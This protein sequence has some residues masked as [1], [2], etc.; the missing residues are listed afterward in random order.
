VAKDYETSLV[1]TVS[2]SAGVAVL[3]VADPSATSTGRLSNGSFTLTRPIQARAGNAAFAPVTGSQNPVTLRAY[4]APVTADQVTIGLRQAILATEAL[5]TG[6]YS[7]AL[8]FTL[9]TATP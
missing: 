6:T 5:R 3:S 4:T 7:T 8:T 9:S 1:A 2:S